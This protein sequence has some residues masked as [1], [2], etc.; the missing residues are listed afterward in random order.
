MFRATLLPIFRSIRLY[1]TI[2][3]MLYPLCCRSVIWWR[4]SY[5]SRSSDLVT[6][7][8]RDQVTDRQ[9]IG[10][11]ISQAVLY[12]IMLLKM[13][14]SFARNMSRKFGF[15]NK[16]LLLHLAGFLLYHQIMICSKPVLTYT[17][18]FIITWDL[19]SQYT[20]E[21][22]FRHVSGDQPED[23]SISTHTKN[24]GPSL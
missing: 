4:S 6:E 20:T 21:C 18:T 17:T 15:I 23:H 7:F 16:P 24:M 10:Y 3:G 14:K 5:V 19:Y 12:S 11:I 8:L 1:N 22:Y 9:H 2:C 13:G